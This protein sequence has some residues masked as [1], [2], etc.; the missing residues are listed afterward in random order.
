M[1]YSFQKLIFPQEE[2][3]KHYG[4]PAE[5]HEITTTDG[6]ILTLQ[7]I[8]YGIKNPPTHHQKPVVFLMP[9]LL[10]TSTCFF[11]NGIENSLAFLL[12]EEGYDV[13][14]GNARGTTYARKHVTLNPDD[15]KSEFW[16][17]SWHEIGVFDVPASIDYVLQQTQQKSLIYVGHSQG[18]T[19]FFV[20]ASE[21]PEYNQK[22]KLAVSLA[23]VAFMPNIPNSAS[24]QLAKNVKIL[25]LIANAINFYEILPQLK[26]FGVLVEQFCGVGAETQEKCIEIYEKIMGANENQ[27]NAVKLI[28]NLITTKIIVK[29]F[30]YRRT[31]LFICLI[32]LLVLLLN[33]SIIT[34]KKL[35]LVGITQNNQQQKILSNIF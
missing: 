33:N 2:L 25:E 20:M 10:A 24:K 15:D 35:T 30:I 18:T 9:G 4:Y 17:F 11:F 22:V 21:R 7:R 32:F 1:F 6:Y 27:L 23:P 19:N 31:F 16:N 5:N 14:L 8:P 34:P 26:I 29:N 3:I 28:A 12:A 13:W